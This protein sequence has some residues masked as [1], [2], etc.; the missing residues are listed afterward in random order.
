MIFESEE[1][2]TGGEY[3]GIMVTSSLSLSGRKGPVYWP[4]IY[5]RI[6]SNNYTDL[7][8]TASVLTYIRRAVCG[9]AAAAIYVMELSLAE[10]CCGNLTRPTLAV[11]PGLSLAVGVTAKSTRFTQ[12]SPASMPNP[13]GCKLFFLSHR[14]IRIRFLRIKQF[15]LVR[16]YPGYGRFCVSRG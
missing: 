5:F 4:G 14:I 9:A 2:K 16:I 10:L 1:P 15:S 8:R 12:T 6:G 11:L 7:P 3:N 13:T